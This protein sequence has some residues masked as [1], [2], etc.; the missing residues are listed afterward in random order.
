MKREAPSDDKCNDSAPAPHTTRRSDGRPP[1]FGIPQPMRSHSTDTQF[2]AN[3]GR[4][5]P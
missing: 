1:S 2:T 4:C 3:S 5:R